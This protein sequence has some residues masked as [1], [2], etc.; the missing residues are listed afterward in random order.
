MS[1]QYKAKEAAYFPTGVISR[2]VSLK[3]KPEMQCIVALR[4]RTTTVLTPTESPVITATAK[5][6]TRSYNQNKH[7][8]NRN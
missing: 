7:I 6:M 4:I 3:F 5:L 8:I 2:V 1:S